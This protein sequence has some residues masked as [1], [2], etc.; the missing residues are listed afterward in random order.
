[1]RWKNNLKIDN[2][3]ERKGNREEGGRKGGETR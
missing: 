3:V 2:G 1:M